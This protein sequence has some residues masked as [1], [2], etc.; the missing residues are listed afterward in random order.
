MNILTIQVL[1][2]RSFCGHR[3]LVMVSFRPL[4]YNLHDKRRHSFVP[5]P[6]SPSVPTKTRMFLRLR[7]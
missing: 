1:S 7:P 6:R 4:V 5:V 3:Y 2:M